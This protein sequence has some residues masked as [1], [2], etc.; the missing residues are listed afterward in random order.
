MVYHT[1]PKIVTNGLV[2][3]LDAADRNSYP[4]SGASW[5]D[6]SGNGYNGTLTNGPTFSS[7]NAGVFSFDGS[8]DYIQLLSPSSRFA[9]TPSGDGMN[10]MTIDF[11]VKTTDTG[12]RIISKPWNGNGQYNISISYSSFQLYIGT[13]GVKNFS[14]MA[15][16]NWENATC[17]VNPTQMGVYRNG[18]VY[19]SFINHNITNN[20]P[21]STNTNIPLSLMTYILM[22]LELGNYPVT[23]LMELYPVLEFTTEFYLRTKYAGITT[24]QKAALAYN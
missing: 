8:N 14:G 11:W 24:Q 12:G 1:G 2:L 22:E 16:G 17:V 9:W 15:T 3:C 4:G 7:D 19:G 13:Y 20:S 18:S 5:L 21:P 10:Y 23:L 6:L